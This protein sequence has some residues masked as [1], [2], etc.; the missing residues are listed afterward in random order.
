MIDKHTLLETAKFI[1]TKNPSGNPNVT[2]VALWLQ[3]HQRIEPKEQDILDFV[4]SLKESLASLYD[5]T[6]EDVRHVVSFIKWVDSITEYEDDND[7][8]IPI[9]PGDVIRTRIHTRPVPPPV[10]IDDVTL[11]RAVDVLSARP[12]VLYIDD[13]ESSIDAAM[14]DLSPASYTWTDS[15]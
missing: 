7:T 1:L 15:T 8:Y 5:V 6:T 2:K 10:D 14:P 4:E 3:G 12:P 11:S 9:E 13:V